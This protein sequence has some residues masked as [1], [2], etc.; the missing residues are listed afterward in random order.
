MN[1]HVIATNQFD[2]MLDAILEKDK[3]IKLG[4]V[5]FSYLGK[6]RCCYDIPTEHWNT[7]AIAKD[8]TKEAFARKFYWLKDPEEKQPENIFLTNNVGAE[9]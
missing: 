6:N 7:T 8:L 2:K 9:K 4:N 3:A 1:K 5:T